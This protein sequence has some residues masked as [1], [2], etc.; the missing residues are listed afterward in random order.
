M[1]HA[2]PLSLVL[3]AALGVAGCTSTVPATT[4]ETSAAAAASPSVSEESAAA[5]ITI[6]DPWAKAT[7]TEMTGAFGTLGNNTDADIHVV[8]VSSTLTDRAELHETVS[9]DGSMMMREMADGFVIPAGGQFVLEPGG[10]HLMLMDLTTPVE[11]GTDVELTLEFED[12]GTFSWLAPVR[13]FA[14]AQE[15]YIE[16]TAMPSETG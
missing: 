16:S 7:D 4:P 10:N 11:A 12:G 6:A 5:E 1:T 3:A 13:T 8:A 9:Q 2:L 14:G 15:E